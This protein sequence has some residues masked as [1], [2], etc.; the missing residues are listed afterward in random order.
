MTSW[1]ERPRL[2]WQALEPRERGLLGFGLALLLP[3]TLYLYVWQPMQEERQRL[4]IRAD[5]L[6]EELTVLRT[7]AE[8][9][10]RMRGAPVAAAASLENA[11]RQGAAQ[12]GVADR[13]QGLTPQGADRL[14]VRF[15]A[16]PF[17]AWLR[18]L[19]Q[20]SSQGVVLAAC[21]V[22]ALP[23]PGMARVRATLARSGG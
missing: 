23:T 14:E 17:D 12:A 18:W 3:V 9:V 1:L 8:E 15:D 22:E 10:K 21:Q 5:Q 13:L 4:A 19:G 20:L 16:V 7:R 6:R 2:R 11:A